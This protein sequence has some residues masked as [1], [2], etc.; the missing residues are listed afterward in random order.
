MDQIK[1]KTMIQDTHYYSTII[2]QWLNHLFSLALTF[3]SFE[4]SWIGIII[5]KKKHHWTHMA[6]AMLMIVV[7]RVYVFLSFLGLRFYRCSGH[8]SPERS[9]TKKQKIN[10]LH[11]HTFHSFKSSENEN[12]SNRNWSKKPKF[13]SNSKHNNNNNNNNSRAIAW[14]GYINHYRCWAHALSCFLFNILILS[15]RFYVTHNGY[16]SRD[17]SS[18]SSNDTDQWSYQ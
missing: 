15:F 12:H 9:K 13:I 7:T 3:G 4:F 2:I 8:E 17:L 11:T 10:E 14:L 18:S 1:K 16:L 5:S 6:L